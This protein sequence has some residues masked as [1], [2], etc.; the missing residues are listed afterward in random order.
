MSAPVMPWDVSSESAGEETP[1]D[2][3]PASTE[4]RRISGPAADRHRST[5]RPSVRQRTDGETVG[6]AI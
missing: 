5:V 3:E 4:R 1:V 6:I 2:Q